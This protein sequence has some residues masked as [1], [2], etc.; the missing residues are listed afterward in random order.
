M[1]QSHE[2]EG[3]KTVVTIV[4]G[5]TVAMLRIAIGGP[6]SDEWNTLLR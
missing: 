6:F 5:I 3:L 1:G 4:V 2:Q